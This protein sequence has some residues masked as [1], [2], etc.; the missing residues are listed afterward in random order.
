[1]PSSMGQLRLLQV[2]LLSGTWLE[3]LDKLRDKHYDQD[4]RIVPTAEGIELESM[5]DHDYR[6][7]LFRRHEKTTGPEELSLAERY[8]MNKSKGEISPMVRWQMEILH[9]TD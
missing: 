5:S 1:M 9:N 3:A 2:R 4:C 6:A 7:V 8:V